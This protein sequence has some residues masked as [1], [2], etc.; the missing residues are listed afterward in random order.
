MTMF[1]KMTNRGTDMLQ[2]IKLIE[3]YMKDYNQSL[4]GFI[5]ELEI[6]KGEQTKIEA[7]D[8]WLVDVSFRQFAVIFGLGVIIGVILWRAVGLV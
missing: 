3:K 6:L 7:K 5:G 4:S 1:C 8:R 2:I